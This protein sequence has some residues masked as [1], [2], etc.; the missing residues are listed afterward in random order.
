MGILFSLLNEQKVRK[1]FRKTG[2]SIEGIFG[3][4]S[5][6]SGGFGLEV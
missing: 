3:K 5:R 4:R 2:F 1:S 6:W